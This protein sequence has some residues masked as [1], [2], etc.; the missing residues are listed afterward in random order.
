MSAV[1]HLGGGP[2]AR[3]VDGV[4]S[5]VTRVLTLGKVKKVQPLAKTFEKVDSLVASVVDSVANI[6]PQWTSREWNGTR[7]YLERVKK[8]LANCKKTTE[9]ARKAKKEAKKASK[10]AHK[11]EESSHG[12]DHGHDKHPT[13]APEKHVEKHAPKEHLPVAHGIEEHGA[14]AKEPKKEG[15]HGH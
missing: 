10:A 4:S 2:I 15:T 13:E 14:H 3:L 9:D 6:K 12:E 11:A 8:K 7:G 5:G 1:L